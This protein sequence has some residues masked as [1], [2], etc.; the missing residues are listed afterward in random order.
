[1]LT[2]PGLELDRLQTICSP[3]PLTIV[4]LIFHSVFL[5]KCEFTGCNLTCGDSVS[6]WF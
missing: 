1:M 6:E 5:F 3:F 4:K 2:F